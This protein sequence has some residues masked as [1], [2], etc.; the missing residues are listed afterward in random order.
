VLLL[1]LLLCSLWI[2]LLL[3]HARV[4]WRRV[5]SWR[6]LRLHLL[7]L[8]CRSLPLLLLVATRR[9]LPLL[10]LLLLLM[11]AWPLRWLLL[12]WTM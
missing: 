2:T 3:L 4:H 9:L 10:L 6:L 12:I 11:C 1:L 8:W 7:L 5:P